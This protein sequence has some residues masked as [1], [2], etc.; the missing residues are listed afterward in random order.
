MVLKSSS[1]VASETVDVSVSALD[2]VSSE[3]LQADKLTSIKQKNKA[4][5][6]EINDN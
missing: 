5:F 3:L 1:A 4:L 6:R 2:E